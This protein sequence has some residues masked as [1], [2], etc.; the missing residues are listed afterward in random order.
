MVKMT[1]AIGQLARQ[2][3]SGFVGL[4]SILISGD[5]FYLKYL[6][7]FIFLIISFIMFADIKGIKRIKIIL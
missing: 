1:W 2:K 7:S 5:F 4:H 3:K 6:S